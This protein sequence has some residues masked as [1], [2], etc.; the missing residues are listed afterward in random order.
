MVKRVKEALC[1]YEIEWKCQ[2]RRRYLVINV[3]GE[4]EMA[5]CKRYEDGIRMR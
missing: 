5:S 4:P 1:E 3:N 2:R